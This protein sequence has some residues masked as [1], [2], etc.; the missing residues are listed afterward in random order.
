[1]PFTVGDRL[2]SMIESLQ[3]SLEVSMKKTGSDWPKGQDGSNICSPLG[4]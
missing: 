3:E 4:F 1:M 2:V